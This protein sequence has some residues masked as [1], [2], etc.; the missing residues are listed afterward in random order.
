MGDFFSSA[1]WCHLHTHTQSHLLYRGAPEEPAIVIT[2]GTAAAAAL[3]AAR[4]LAETS[5]RGGPKREGQL[6]AKQQTKKNRRQTNR[7]TVRV[8]AADT[9]KPR[10]QSVS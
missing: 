6:R 2:T 7:P 3:S 8:I 5:V 4:R 10:I 9:D 1:L